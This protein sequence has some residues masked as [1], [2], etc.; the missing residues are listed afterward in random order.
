M[1]LVPG[2]IRAFV[3]ST[4]GAGEVGNTRRKTNLTVFLPRVPERSKFAAHLLEELEAHRND[5]LMPGEYHT[6]KS[7][8][9]ACNARN[10]TG[11]AD[12]TPAAEAGAAG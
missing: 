6:A 8:V 5:Y 10:A 3:F 7:L 11:A 9:A 12:N 1:G 4:P 2:G